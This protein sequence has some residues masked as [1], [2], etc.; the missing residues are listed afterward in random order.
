MRA[1]GFAHEAEDEGAR[2]RRREGEEKEPRVTVQERRPDSAADD[3]GPELFDE[4]P[5][6]ETIQG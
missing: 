1:R 6:E 4:S 3:S 2:T 5:K